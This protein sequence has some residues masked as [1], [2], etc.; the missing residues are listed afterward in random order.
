MRESTI[1]TLSEI[2]R[3]VEDA[4]VALKV[5]PKSEREVSKHM[6][7]LKHFAEEFDKKFGLI[8]ESVTE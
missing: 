3:L 1:L 4:E 6:K 7:T 5:L 8:E 2:E